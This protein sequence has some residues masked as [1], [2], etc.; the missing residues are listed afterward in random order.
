ME[1]AINCVAFYVVS[2]LSA[3]NY[4]KFSRYQ[5]EM[6]NIAG[7]VHSSQ[8][9]CS[10]R[11]AY[12][13]GSTLANKKSSRR[14][15]SCSK[16]ESKSLALGPALLATRTHE[17]CPGR[18]YP[19]AGTGVLERYSRAAPNNYREQYLGPTTQVSRE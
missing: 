11:L 9:Q 5:A 8:R 1:A 19:H 14:Q 6:S 13:P 4:A 2:F 18:L 12:R 3:Q 16:Y 15:E 17:Q 10:T 7:H